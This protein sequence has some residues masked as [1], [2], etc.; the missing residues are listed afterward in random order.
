MAASQLPFDFTG[1]LNYVPYPGAAKI[2]VPVNIAGQFSSKSDDKYEIV[3]AQTKSID[4]GTCSSAGCKVLLIVYLAGTSPIM[5]KVNG[6]LTEE[7]LTPGGARLY[8]DPAPA[9][10]ITSA[11]I[12]TTTDATVLAIVLGLPFTMTSLH[13]STFG[14]CRPCKGSGYGVHLGGGSRLRDV[15][16]TVGHAF[17]A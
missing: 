14:H 11:S 7:E 12:T 17:E 8:V 4:F 13:R 6:S 10:G 1:T 16:E 15:V 5:V 9:T 3:G 2:P